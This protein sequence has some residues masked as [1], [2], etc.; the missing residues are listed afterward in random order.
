MSTLEIREKLI[1][2]ILSLMG[3]KSVDQISI[4]EIAKEAEV[5]SAAISYYFGGK[6][7]LILEAMKVYWK[8]LCNLYSR[9][10]IGEMTK[11]RAEA[12]CYEIFQFYIR[13]KGIIQAEQKIFEANRKIDEDTKGRITLQFHAM[14]YMIKAL[15]PEVEKEI[16]CIKVI[17]LM[18][19]LSH[20]VIWL[21]MADQIKPAE[22]ELEELSRAYIKDVVDNI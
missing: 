15:R 16:I 5:N 22:L 20:P 1:H 8:E 3:K 9:M 17:R 12:C 18:S 21:D 4:R 19:A 6:D 13:S 7:N 11:E 10:L 14:G 2:S